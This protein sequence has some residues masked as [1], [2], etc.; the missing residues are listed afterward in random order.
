MKQYLQ[1]RIFLAFYH[2]ILYWFCAN[3]E[4]VYKGDDI[5]KGK[6]EVKAKCEIMKMKR[7]YKKADKKIW[8]VLRCKEIVALCDFLYKV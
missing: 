1:P 7:N 8:T 4:K 6:V 2:N 5:C 3:G